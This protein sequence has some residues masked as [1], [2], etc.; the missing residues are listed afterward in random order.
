MTAKTFKTQTEASQVMGPLYKAGK[1]LAWRPVTCCGRV[2]VSVF[3]GAAWLKLTEADLA[4]I[5]A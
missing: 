3:M 2:T 1:V 5:A 4:K